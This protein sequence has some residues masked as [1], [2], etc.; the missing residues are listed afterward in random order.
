MGCS[1]MPQ[2]Q[3]SQHLVAGT[4]RSHPYNDPEGWRTC[5][6]LLAGRISDL[7]QKGW[8]HL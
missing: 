5:A 7:W 4:L 6:G 3:M 2:T 1:I 8:V